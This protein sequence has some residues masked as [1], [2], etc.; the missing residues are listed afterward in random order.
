MNAYIPSTGP[1]AILQLQKGMQE[2]I[3]EMDILKR[4]RRETRPARQHPQQRWRERESHQGQ[5]GRREDN[6]LPPL[7]VQGPQERV[8][9]SDTMPGSLPPSKTEGIWRTR[10]RRR[11]WKRN[12]TRSSPC[13]ARLKRLHF[14]AHTQQIYGRGYTGQKNGF[15]TSERYA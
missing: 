5:Q 11:P 14:K 10:R 8:G 15:T 3:Q 1:G 2:I 12:L 4:E 7:H 6:P 13:H 9:A